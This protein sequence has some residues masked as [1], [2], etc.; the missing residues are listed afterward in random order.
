MPNEFKTMN[1]TVITEEDIGR[2]ILIRG[3]NNEIKE[4]VLIDFNYKYHMVNVFSIKEKGIGEIDPGCIY[5]LGEH[6]NFNFIE[7]YNQ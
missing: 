1:G 2:T 4:G 3:L 7:S 6:V 5:E